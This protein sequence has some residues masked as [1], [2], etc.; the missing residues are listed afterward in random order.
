MSDSRS[1]S[2]SQLL[3][4]AAAGLLAVSMTACSAAGLVSQVR[5]SL[6]STVTGSNPQQVALQATVQS[7]AA[8]VQPAVTTSMDQ[9]YENLYAQVN[10]SVVNITVV[11]AG[12]ASGT[13]TL[14]NQGPNATPIAP[15]N[16]SAGTGVALGSGFVYDSQGDIVTNNHVVAGATKITVTFADGVEAA[17][18]VVGASPDADLAVIKVSVN[19]NELHPLALA[20]SDALK[21]GQGVVAIGNP[22]GLAGSMTTGIVSGLGRL[23]SDGG[24]SASG[25]SYSI[26]DIVQTDAAINPGNSGGPLLDLSGNVV[27]VNTAIESSTQ[28]SSGVGY[29]IPADI[30]GQVAQVLIKQGKYQTP[31]LGI[32]GVSLGS[33]LAKAM[34]LDPNTR[35]VLVEDVTTGGP[36]DKAGLKASTQQTT[37]AGLPAQI[38]GDVIVSVDGHAVKQFDDL[39]SYLF[40]HGTVGQQVTLG[41]LRN[42]QTT[43]VSVTLGARPA[44]TGG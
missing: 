43:N 40:R 31:Y 42:G 8:A 35:G 18:T 6:S 24:Q 36:A 28:Q 37:V 22:F 30:V 5:S 9:L 23:L 33:D 11:V 19:A 39:L 27:A 14:G 12:S 15:T 3:K 1:G 21:V 17:A 29:G 26:P 10:P 20:E 13:G 32:S 25:G 44:T 38:G 2:S 4:Y 34:N 41:V 16:P 7:P